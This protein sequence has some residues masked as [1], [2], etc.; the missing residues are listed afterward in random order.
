MNRLGYVV[1]G[2]SVAWKIAYDGKEQQTFKS[3]SDTYDQVLVDA[4]SVI[5]EKDK[6]YRL[7]KENYIKSKWTVNI[8]S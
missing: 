4:Q 7:F 6:E 8:Y 5:D 3:Y 1:G 2:N